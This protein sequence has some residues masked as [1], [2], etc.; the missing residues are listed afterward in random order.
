MNYFSKNASYLSMLDRL[1]QAK[2]MELI[3]R[4]TPP[5]LPVLKDRSQRLYELLKQNKDFDEMR[6][7]NPDKVNVNQTFITAHKH[8]SL[9][10]DINKLSPIYIKEMYVN[11]VNYGKFLICRTLME[12]FKMVATAFLVEDENGDVEE[13]CLYNYSLDNKLISYFPKAQ[14]YL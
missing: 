3:N 9:E 1:N 2:E 12:G 6:K 5:F 7:K 13:V 10:Q 14:Y 8:S 11:K 4:S